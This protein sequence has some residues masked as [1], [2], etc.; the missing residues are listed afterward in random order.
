MPVNSHRQNVPSVED[1]VELMFRI[2][3]EPPPS[4]DTSDEDSLTDTI[5]PPRPSRATVALIVLA[6]GF[7]VLSVSYMVYHPPRHLIDEHIRPYISH[8]SNHLPEPVIATSQ[9][10]SIIFNRMRTYLP[11]TR[12]TALLPTTF[13]PIKSEDM[14]L[15]DMDSAEADFMLDLADEYIPL[16]VGMGWN[17]RPGSARPIRN[18]GSAKS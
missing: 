1:V 4:N 17:G 7:C 18:Y 11:T 8:I 9:R 12:A 3:Q 16:S 13:R 15:L 2:T 14:R 10:L 6:I 5:S